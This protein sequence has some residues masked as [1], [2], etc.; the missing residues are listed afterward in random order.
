LHE[1]EDPSA[2]THR[3][4]AGHASDEAGAEQASSPTMSEEG[5]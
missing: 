1:V 4:E 2:L 5:E 3:A